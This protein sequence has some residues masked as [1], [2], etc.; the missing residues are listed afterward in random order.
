MVIRLNLSL[1]NCQ[2]LDFSITYTFSMVTANFFFAHSAGE[3]KFIPTFKTRLPSNLGRLPTNGH[4]WS[5]DKI[6]FTPFDQS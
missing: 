2:A 1:I 6:A 3:L 5:R 4:F